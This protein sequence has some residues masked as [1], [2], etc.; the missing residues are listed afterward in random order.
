MKAL[1]SSSSCKLKRPANS[2]YLAIGQDLFSI[3]EYISSQY[4]YSLHHHTSTP[5][6]PPLPSFRDLIPST[7]MVYASLKSIENGLFYPTDYGSG[8]E[9]ADGIIEMYGDVGVQIGLWLDGED[10][11]TKIVNGELDK[12]IDLLVNY[13]YFECHSSNIFLRLGYGKFRLVFILFIT[14]DVQ[15]CV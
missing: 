1:S 9:Y 6:P 10:G 11:C 8:V 15:L 7:F 14:F 5:P 2:T 13:L 3:E 12:Q 4:N